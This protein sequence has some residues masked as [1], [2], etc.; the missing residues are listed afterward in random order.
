[1]QFGAPLRFHAD[2]FCP[3]TADDLSLILKRLN[4]IA[5]GLELAAALDDRMLRDRGDAGLLQPGNGQEG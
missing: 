3:G 2:L 5:A 1:M 4:D